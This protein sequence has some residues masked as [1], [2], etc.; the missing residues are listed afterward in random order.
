[1]VK[2]Q[3]N[4]NTLTKHY[5][6][7]NNNAAMVRAQRQAQEKSVNELI[8]ESRKRAVAQAITAGGLASSSSS[9]ASASSSSGSAA[10]QQTALDATTSGASSNGSMSLLAYLAD[11]EAFDSRPPDTEVEPRRRSRRTYAGPPPPPTWLEEE[12][13]RFAS[14]PYR[15]HMQHYQAKLW[16]AHLIF[17]PQ[18]SETYNF[19]KNL[20]DRPLSTL[21]SLLPRDRSLQHWCYV[22]LARDWDFYVEYLQLYLP[23][24]EPS[25]KMI[26]LAYL[27]RYSY[28]G[29]GAQGF[30]LLFDPAFR[31]EEPAA[32]E[33]SATLSQQDGDDWSI[34][35]LDDPNDRVTSL[36]LS[37]QIDDVGFPL[38]RLAKF[39]SARHTTTAESWQQ[40]IPTSR[41][42]TFLSALSLSYPRTKSPTRLWSTV[43]SLLRAQSSLIALSLANWPI[44]PDMFYSH[45]E[46]AR[47][48]VYPATESVSTLLQ[49][50][51]SSLSLKWIDFSGCSWL[52]EWVIQSFEW[53]NSWRNLET[54]V[55]REIDKDVCQRIEKVIDAVRGRAGSIK[56]VTE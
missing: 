56:I 39:M 22:R 52:D 33:E 55:L 11:P 1:M 43:I 18:D 30:R 20:P 26:L 5:A 53:T 45:T 21:V 25:V 51:K 9:S 6:A 44:P 40:A 31:N 15:L 24:L 54:L 16:L 10:A 28:N 7:M 23:F 50:S 37:Y 34:P 48:Q 3:A 14:L 8:W 36:D 38:G 49:L 19:R 29:V 47:A 27:G 13:V 4:S 46:E 32:D 2:H 41:T 17:R 42:F 35:A 12:R